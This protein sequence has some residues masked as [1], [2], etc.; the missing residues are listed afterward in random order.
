MYAYHY[1]HKSFAPDLKKKVDAQRAARQQAAQSN[2][3]MVK[4]NL[5]LFVAF[6]GLKRILSLSSRRAIPM[7]RNQYGR[8]PRSNSSENVLQFHLTLAVYNRDYRLQYV[9]FD[10][11]V[12]CDFIT[13][14]V[15]QQLFQ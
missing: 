13:V 14:C 7:R 4:N 3:E 1:V 5:T 12:L 11:V 8:T 10:V 9:Y 6:P 15:E 2:N